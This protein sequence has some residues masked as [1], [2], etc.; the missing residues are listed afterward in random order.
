MLRFRRRVA[1]AQ[2]GPGK[3]RRVEVRGKIPS[4]RNNGTRSSAGVA[5]DGRLCVEIVNAKRIHE[6]LAVLSGARRVSPQVAAV[7]FATR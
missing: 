2:L 3:Q 6:G 5:E 7:P 1:V 4:R